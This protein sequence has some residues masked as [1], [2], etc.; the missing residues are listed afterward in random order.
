MKSWSSYQRK[1]RSRTRTKIPNNS[2][3]KAQTLTLIRTMVK[4]QRKKEEKEMGIPQC[5]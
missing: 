3:Q 5:C 4:P 2:K 1:R